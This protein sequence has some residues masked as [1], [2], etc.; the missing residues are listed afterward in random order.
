M[1]GVVDGQS[2]KGVAGAGALVVSTP[3]LDYDETSMAVLIGPL[4]VLSGFGLY[5]GSTT[6]LG[7]FQRTPW[8]FLAVSALG[9]V[10]AIAIALRDGGTASIAAAGVSVVL[11]AFLVWFFFGYSMY[12][13][14]EDRPRLGDRFPEFRLPTSEG[15]V[16]DLAA[17]RGKRHL[18]IFYRGSW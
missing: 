2:R 1:P 6:F 15:G 5:M 3:R 7:R 16:F 13:T 4:L 8:E 14:R 9:P 18:L 11:F 10:A 12:T 17:E